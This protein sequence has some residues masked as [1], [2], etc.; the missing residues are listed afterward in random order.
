ML[1]RLSAEGSEHYRDQQEIIPAL[2]GA[3][4]ILVANISTLFDRNK[5]SAA[6]FRELNET[7]CF[8]TSWFGEID[9][10]SELFHA[11][12]IIGT[13][14]SL[15][16]VKLWEVVAVYPEFESTSYPTQPSTVLINP[17]DSLRRPDVRY[18]APIKAAKRYTQEE[19]ARLRQDPFSPGNGMLSGSLKEYGYFFG[20]K[21]RVTST[22]QTGRMITIFPHPFHEFRVV[23]ITYLKVPKRV[24]AITDSMQWPESMTELIVA[25]AL[26][27][28]AYKQGDGTNLNMM[29]Q[30]ELSML[31]QALV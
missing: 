18:S 1:F 10:D 31:T 2:N 25:M 16:P 4:D 12:P 28:I 22:P 19:V 17:V 6:A 26:R 27:Q 21:Q 8:Q 14:T 3:Q 15:E 7:M 23:A 13:G 5:A 20:A 9:L 24:A 29:T 11:D 30:G